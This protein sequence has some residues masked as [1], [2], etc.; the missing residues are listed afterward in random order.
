MWGEKM[1]LK[2]HMNKVHKRDPEKV[3]GVK[4]DGKRK[5][6]SCEECMS[7]VVHLGRHMQQVHKKVLVKKLQ[8]C[9]I[10]GVKKFRLNSH[11]EVHRKDPEKN[12]SATVDGKQRKR[13]QECMSEVVDLSQHMRHVH[14][15]KLEKRR[16]QCQEC[17]SEVVDL[18]QHMRHV[19]EKKLGKQTG[20]ICDRTYQRQIH[21]VKHPLH[22]CNKCK[23][24]FRTAESLKNHLIGHEKD[25]AYQTDSGV[26]VCGNC[27]AR[28]DKVNKFG[29][30]RRRYCPKKMVEE[31]SKKDR[32]LPGADG[33]IQPAV[34]KNE[35]Y[36]LKP[37]SENFESTSKLGS[38]YHVHRKKKKTT[39][40]G[41][42]TCQKCNLTFAQFKTLREHN[43]A[44]HMNKGERIHKCEICGKGFFH[45]RL[46]DD[47][48]ESHLVNF[49]GK[50]RYCD[51]M[52]VNAVSLRAHERIN[53]RFRICEFCGENVP[54][55]SFFLHK[56]KGCKKKL[57]AKREKGRKRLKERGGANR[58]DEDKES[59]QVVALHDEVKR[60][61][62]GAGPK[63]NAQ[64]NISGIEPNQH[65]KSA[66]G[67]EIEGIELEA[68]SARLEL[69][70]S[71]VKHR[72]VYKCSKCSVAFEFKPNFEAHKRTCQGPAVSKKRR[73]MMGRK[74]NHLVKHKSSHVKNVWTYLVHQFDFVHMKLLISGLSVNFVKTFF[75]MKILCRCTSCWNVLENLKLLLTHFKEMEK[76]RHLVIINQRVTVMDKIKLGQVLIKR[77]L[78]MNKILLSHVA[79]VNQ[80]ASAVDKIRLNHVAMMDQRVAV[81]D[82]MPLS[83]G[84]IIKQAVSVMD[85]I[86]LS[87]VVII[88]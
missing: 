62:Q 65:V 28:F 83:H 68:D 76:V 24:E 66:A 56:K 14:K 72:E 33:Q 49:R 25:K 54:S 2:D 18:S 44:I 75:L 88:S 70:V 38:H 11:M 29:Q 71:Q 50:C 20:K 16:K 61:V 45:K 40:Q 87:H 55:K 42:V 85:K 60:I 79:T 39:S 58:R 47:H 52:F 77:V 36:K 22:F 10:C 81:M 31:E 21:P 23:R 8:T 64:V 1:R 4:V 41:F 26:F 53:H 63:N 30:H 34:D 43:T 13:C 35:S 6:R 27:M 82:K 19:H 48:K 46:L 15:K 78:V 9:K 17:M 67:G 80:A 73:V 59:E 84:A 51:L 3:G 37:C 74:R 57:E 7:E 12:G 86:N 32:E 5:K 69:R